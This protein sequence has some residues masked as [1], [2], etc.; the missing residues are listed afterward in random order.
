[1]ARRLDLVGRTFG[2]LTVVSLEYVNKY[3]FWTCA[4]TCGG[5]TTVN[6]SLL[7]SGRVKSCGCLKKLP[8]EP[9][10]CKP[11]ASVS[12]WTCLEFVG[13]G[14]RGHEFL[15]QHACGE[16]RVVLASLLRAGKQARCSCQPKTSRKGSGRFHGP[17][18]NTHKAMVARCTNPEHEAYGRYGE[19]GITL[20]P[21]WLDYD[22]FV[23]EM[24]ERPRGTE[25]DRIDNSLGYFKGNCRWVTRKVNL[26]NTRVNVRFLFR[27]E[28]KTIADLADI[29]AVP[30]PTLYARLTK[31]M[32]DVE[33]AVTTPSRRGK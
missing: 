7:A 9:I 25:I 19:V 31:Y 1:M 27:G 6:G 11:G 22:T 17:T 32:W 12:G 20:D 21:A 14:A 23:S 4:C 8:K 16:R 10:S 33:K 29:A 26:R 15:W 5:Y 30:Y 18:R 24:G 2:R 3:T 28:E 13:R